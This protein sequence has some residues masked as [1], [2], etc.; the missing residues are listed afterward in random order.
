M[1][2]RMNIGK[3]LAQI[4]NCKTLEEI[5]T[6]LQDHNLEFD[7]WYLNA[8]TADLKQQSLYVVAY[9]QDIDGVFIHI[10]FNF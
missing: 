4:K 6:F 9:Y 5:K 10:T 3:E 7:H 1:G 8:N 2:Y